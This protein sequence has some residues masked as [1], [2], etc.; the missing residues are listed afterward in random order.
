MYIFQVY[1]FKYSLD[2]ATY[3]D[4]LTRKQKVEALYIFCNFILDVEH[5]QNKL[6]NSPNIRHMLNVKPLGYDL[7]KSVY[8]YFGSNKLYREDFEKSFDLSTNLPVDN[9]SKMGFI[10]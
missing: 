9:V 7:N 6:S 1:N 3:F 10:I 2:S 4:D 5:I 8:W